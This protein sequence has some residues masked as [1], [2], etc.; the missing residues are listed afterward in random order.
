MISIQDFIGDKAT[1]DDHGQKIWAV[2]KQGKMQML[3]DL[4]G[5]GAIQNLFLGPG[6]TL[7]Q[8]AA[9]KFQD[10]LGQYIADAITEKLKRDA[11]N[12]QSK[13]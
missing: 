13:P 5:W 9:A 3:C 7:D 6:G 1:Y 8:E 2:D 11:D 4:R 12:K 10:E